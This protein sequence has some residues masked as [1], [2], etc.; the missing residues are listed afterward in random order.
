MYQA[1]LEIVRE[2][3]RVNIKYDVVDNQDDGYSLVDAGFRACTGTHVSV[4]FISNDDDN[5]FEVR[6]FSL[7]HVPDEKLSGALKLVNE[8]NRKYR[9][10]KFVIDN[11]GD[12]NL[13][14]D[15]PMKSTSI[16]PC[17]AEMFIRFM[18]IIDEALPDFMRF[19]W[20]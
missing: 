4:K 17:A 9:F 11:D 18:K 19:I 14:Y 2:F 3:D 5:D 8:Q 15:M 6:A 10:V 13:E 16:G 7:A 1:T 20:G 12:I